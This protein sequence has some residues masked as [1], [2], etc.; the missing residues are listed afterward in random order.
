MTTSEILQK[1]R[2][3]NPELME[4]SFGCLIDWGD[5]GSKVKGSTTTIRPYRW[6][7]GGDSEEELSPKEMAKTITSCKAKI[8]GHPVQYHHLLL[9]IGNDCGISYGN[10]KHWFIKNGHTFEID[11]TKSVEQNL[12]ENEA[13]REFVSEVLTTI[14]K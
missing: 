2:E 14:N 12:N 5:W 3:A 4:L 10:D 7:D 11:L 13:L 6:F 8:I 9:T 1:I